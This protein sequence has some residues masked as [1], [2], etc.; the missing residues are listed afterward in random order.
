MGVLKCEEFLH[1]TGDFHLNGRGAVTKHIGNVQTGRNSKLAT[2]P[3][4]NIRIT[5]YSRDD[6]TLG[7]VL[8]E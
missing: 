5:F 8:V 1:I 6:Y 3:H 4:K 7:A 2:A